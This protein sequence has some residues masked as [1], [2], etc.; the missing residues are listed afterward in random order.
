MAAT[1]NDSS[2]FVR[3]LPYSVAH[4]V[5]ISTWLCSF[6]YSESVH[7]SWEG[8][9]HVPRTHRSL[10]LYLPTLG[11]CELLVLFAIH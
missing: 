3:G 1:K 8:L 7:T 4:E 11:Q 10:S 6:G 5:C 9:Q 2:V